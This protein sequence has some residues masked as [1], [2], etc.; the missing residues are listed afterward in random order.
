MATNIHGFFLFLT[1]NDHEC[2][3]YLF[4]KSRSEKYI[5]QIVCIYIKFY[6]G[7][8]DNFDLALFKPNLIFSILKEWFWQH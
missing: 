4:D 5:E 2:I 7:I 3:M 1:L 8:W 6:V